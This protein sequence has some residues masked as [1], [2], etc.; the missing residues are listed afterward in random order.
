MVSTEMQEF[1]LDEYVVQ[2]MHYDPGQAYKDVV[3]Y[4]QNV[5]DLLCAGLGCADHVFLAHAECPHPEMPGCL[6]EV[7]NTGLWTVSPH[8]QP[9]LRLCREMKG[10]SEEPRY[11]AVRDLLGDE[12]NDPSVV[13]VLG[14][15][16]L[17]FAPGIIQGHP[18]DCAM[19]R[20]RFVGPVMTE[21]DFN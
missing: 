11:D 16:L 18:C 21:R 12:Y 6:G 4:S 3:K 19:F 7:E 5:L 15:E 20:E 8:T 2:L 17:A 1:R 14:L 13:M 9:V 10:L